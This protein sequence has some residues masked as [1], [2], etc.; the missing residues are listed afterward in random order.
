M[1]AKPDQGVGAVH[2]AKAVQEVVRIL[3]VKHKAE[4]VVGVAVYRQVEADLI[5]DKKNL[6]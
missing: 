5:L 1:A 4:A 2:Q 6:I 3:A